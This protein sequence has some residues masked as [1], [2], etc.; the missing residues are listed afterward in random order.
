MDSMKD[1]IRVAL[2]NVV[3]LVALVAFTSLVYLRTQEPLILLVGGLV[4]VVSVIGS[5][6]GRS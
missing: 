3:G 2:L 1:A 5:A 4:S 6:M